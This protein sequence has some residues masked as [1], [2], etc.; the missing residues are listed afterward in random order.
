MNIIKKTLKQI[1]LFVL[2]KYITYKEFNEFLKY[3]G[4]MEK[5]S[6]DELDNNNSVT[7]TSGRQI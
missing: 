6:L 7:I 3:G 4:L 1:R 5:S 2:D